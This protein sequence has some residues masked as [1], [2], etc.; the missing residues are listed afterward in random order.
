MP[1]WA[2]IYLVV[3]VALHIFDQKLGE[4]DGTSR[5]RLSA[6]LLTGAVFAVLFAGIWLPAI[7][8]ALGF[9]ARA[10][11]VAAVA[12]ELYSTPGDLREMWRDSE[13]S[14]AERIVVILAVPLLI[15][16]LYVMAGVG[17]FT[18]HGRA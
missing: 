3:F 16:P 13:L 4:S 10:L 12:W 8:G 2:I 14:R 11:F 5:L 18:F 17:V 9:A 7:Y 1:W 15:W 6:D